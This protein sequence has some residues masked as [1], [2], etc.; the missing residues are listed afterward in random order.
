MLLN[1]VSRKFD[2]SMKK[3]PI[4]D[5]FVAKY[6]KWTVYP[7]S[8]A[9]QCHKETH[10]PEM[11]NKPDANLHVTIELNMQGEK[12][13]QNYLHIITKLTFLYTIALIVLFIHY[14]FYLYIYLWNRCE[15]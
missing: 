3:D 8:E 13:V 1:Q 2:D 6:Y 9:V 12:K 11:Y 7:F 5:V 10:H 14:I 15:C 4:D